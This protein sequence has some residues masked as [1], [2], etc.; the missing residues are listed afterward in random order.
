MRVRTVVAADVLLLL[1]LL[2][3]VLAGWLV[4]RGFA[5]D[6]PLALGP[7]AC[8]AIAALPAVLWLGYVHGQ[9]RLEASPKHYVIATAL[10]G[11]FV[12]GPVARWMI[13]GA[14]APHPAAG[15][16]LDPFSAARLV[17]IV[18]VVAL[19]QELLKYAVVRYGVY[20]TPELQ[21]PIDAMIYATAAGLGFAA[22]ATFL[23]LRA[24]GGHVFLSAAI[25]RTV[26]HAV[27]HACF[28]AAIGHALAVAKF[29][30]ATPLRRAL[31]LAAGLGLAV[32]LDAQFV[33]VSGALSTRALEA[34]PWRAI[35]YAFGF[36]A[37]VFFVASLRLRRLVALGPA[38]GAP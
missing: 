35:G 33:L 19:G 37:A 8:A 20:R 1:G 2:A 26:V 21:Q 34:T 3:L 17:R 15:V 22:H 11:A 18:L 7:T 27:A 13:G 30:P 38:P 36:A 24:L 10:I 28:A 9:E 5:L 25:A 6:A 12:A 23:D 14:L 16:D 31:R 32:V 29:A 4:E